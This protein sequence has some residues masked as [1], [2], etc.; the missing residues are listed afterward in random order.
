MNA[1]ELTE[2]D[3]G[4]ALE[5]RELEIDLHDLI[6][7]DLAGVGYPYV[8]AHRLPRCHSLHRDGEVAVIED[9]VAESVAKR[10]GGL[11]LKYR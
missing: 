6:P 4:R 3:E 7:L 11:A 5:G 1:L 2:S 10:I 8:D 9:G